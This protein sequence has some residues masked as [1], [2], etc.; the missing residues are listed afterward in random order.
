MISLI[1]S[2]I[3]KGIGVKIFSFCLKEE[4]AKT[5]EEI[6]QNLTAAELAHV[7]Y[8]PYNGDLTNFLKVFASMK[9][10]VAT[11]FHAN[12]LALKFQ[13]RLFP[14]VYNDKTLNLLEDLQIF[15]K[16]EFYDLRNGMRLDLKK[17]WYLLENPKDVSLKMNEWAAV[18]ARSFY[19]L[20]KYLLNLSR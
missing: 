8:V 15:S 19:E 20:D 16:E 14:I 2:A 13:Q 4:D 1:R 11:R 12:V 10:I 5:V 3:G 9:Y 6:A 18:S 17:V 7:Q